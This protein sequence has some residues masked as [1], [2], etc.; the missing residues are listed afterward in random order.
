[1][2]TTE[3]L[4][5]E[6]L[7]VYVGAKDELSSNPTPEE[8]QGLYQLSLDHTLCGVIFDAIGRLDEE[9]QPPHRLRVKW[10]V[11]REKVK[12]TNAT[13]DHDT[14]CV[15]R[16]WKQIGYDSVIL[17]GQGNALLYPKPDCRMSGD[18]DVLVLAPRKEIASYIHR[19]F[20]HTEITRIEAT[21]P[22]LKRTA[23]EVHF[24]PTYLY[25]P[26][27]DTY[28]NRY[29]AEELKRPL[30]VQLADGP[31]LIP[32]DDMN[33]VFQL[34]HIYRH[35]FFEGIGLRQLVDYYF[36]LQ[37]ADI[38]RA[39]VVKVIKRANL[40]HFTRGL[41]WVLGHVF[42]LSAD[43]MLLPPD[44]AEGRFLLQEILRSG[45]FGKADDRVGNR[46]QMSRW[47][48]FVWGTKWGFRLI[49]H[50]PKE[51][52]WQPFYRVTQYLWRVWNGYL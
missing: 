26:F 19:M 14:V 33:V 21:F 27:S 48:R 49:Q 45:N 37:K 8:W 20:P 25:N 35:L 2:N 16:K 36:L 39:K 32:N 9:Q 51:V 12:N 24:A 22:V 7:K 6:L 31:I 17:K 11:V 5:L 29:F 13:M 38:D 46:M 40:S 43:K 18:I 41:M 10:N 30:T 1:M 4:F 28:V 44:E 34:T 23:I 50:Y 42:E 47:E 3:K 15:V 52:L